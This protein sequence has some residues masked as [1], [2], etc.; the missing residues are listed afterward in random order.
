MTSLMKREIEFLQVGFRPNLLS[1]LSPLPHRELSLILDLE[2]DVIHLLSPD[3]Y[4]QQSNSYQ[5]RCF[6]HVVN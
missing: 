4:R 1:L 2:S 6:T 3:G 5:D